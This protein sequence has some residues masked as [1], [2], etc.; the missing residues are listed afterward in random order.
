MPMKESFILQP[1]G[2]TIKMNPSRNLF[3]SDAK[4]SIQ[5]F[6]GSV[7]FVPRKTTNAF[8]AT[9]TA[10]AYATILGNI[11]VSL[12]SISVLKD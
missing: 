6:P 12:A 2:E 9:Q 11:G 7:I 5:V 10:Q 3:M 1:N 8:A 4:N